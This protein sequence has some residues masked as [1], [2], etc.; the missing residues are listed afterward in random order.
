MDGKKRLGRILQREGMACSKAHSQI[1][2][3]IRSKDR[4]ARPDQCVFIRG[5]WTA[6]SGSRSTDSDTMKVVA[7]CRR[8]RKKR[9]DC[10]QRAKL[11]G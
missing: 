11:G 5:A 4:L 8:N 10:R 3:N 9:Q 2:Y 7:G 6:T 1:K